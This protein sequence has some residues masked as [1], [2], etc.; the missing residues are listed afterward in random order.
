MLLI[1][2]IGF[3]LAITC[4]IVYYLHC[5]PSHNIK[6]C[7]TNK[8]KFHF[9]YKERL[10][11]ARF[12]TSH[13]PP[14]NIS[15][16]SSSSS[17]T[18][19]LPAVVDNHAPPLTTSPLPKSLSAT[20]ALN[21]T[22]VDVEENPLEGVDN[23]IYYQQ[24][25]IETKRCTPVK[26]SLLNKN[27]SFASFSSYSSYMHCPLNE[28]VSSIFGGGNN[29]MMSSDDTFHCPPIVKL[30]DLLNG[31]DDEDEEYDNFSRLNKN[32]STSSV[33]KTATIRE[34]SL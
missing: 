19:S 9:I 28:S 33:A 25:P 26:L 15:S 18:S 22:K 23:E 30:R 4:Q 21:T 17:S 16:S 3:W 11:P 2:V 7:V 10:R 29:S 31:D 6:L 5:H 14:N 32:K 34:T 24:E 8:S 20:A 1:V 13:S 12:S 27:S